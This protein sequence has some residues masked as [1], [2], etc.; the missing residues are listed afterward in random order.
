M[1]LSG[2]VAIAGVYEHPLR[3]A[4]DK[5]EWLIMAESARGSRVGR[6][7]TNNSYTAKVDV[8]SYGCTT[9]SFFKGPGWDRE[10]IQLIEPAHQQGGADVVGEVGDHAEWPG[11]QICEFDRERIGLDQL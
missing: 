11:G 4:P 1:S 5:T 3:W 6:P 7:G 8:I 9:G 10:M 2:S